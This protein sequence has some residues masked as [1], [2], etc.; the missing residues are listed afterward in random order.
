M[1]TTLSR[2]LN[3]NRFTAMSGKMAAIVGYVIS[4]RFTNPIITDMCITSDGFVLAQQ[5]GDIGMNETI[6]HISDLER[7]WNLLIRVADLNEIETKQARALYSLRI[8]DWRK[9]AYN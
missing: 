5:E 3:P 4:E 8:K 7:N 2:K 6:G 9:G 1:K